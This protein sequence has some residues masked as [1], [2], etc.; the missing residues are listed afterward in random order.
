[1]KII[2]FTGKKQHG[3]STAVAYL[4]KVFPNATRLN[5]KD[6]L[7][8]EIRERFP[9]VLTE[10]VGV[11]ERMD[12]DGMDPWSVD[13]LFRDKPPLMRALMRNFG[14]EVRRADDPYHWTKAWQKARNAI[15]AEYLF[16]DDVR[17]LNEAQVVRAEGGIIIR[18]VKKGE[19][20]NTDSHASEAEMDGIAVDHT[21]END[22][23]DIEVLY[24]QLDKIFHV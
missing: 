19:S 2:A 24:K 9:E 12:Y 17:F 13:R 16:V 15:E 1:M 10:M 20:L 14:T 4:M 8:A 5:F 21:I 6:A 22:F 7:V 3:K 23:E 18:I 11:Y